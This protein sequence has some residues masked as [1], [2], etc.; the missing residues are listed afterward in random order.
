[1]LQKLNPATSNVSHQL[2][3]HAA[4]LMIGMLIINSHRARWSNLEDPIKLLTIHKGVVC[5]VSREPAAAVASEV[6]WRV[7]TR[8]VNSI[9]SST[10]SLHL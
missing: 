6:E 5:Q 3:K 1:M 8:K 9:G 10:S 7:F 4:G 2:T